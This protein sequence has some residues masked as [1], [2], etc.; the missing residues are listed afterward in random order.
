[1]ANCL[2][3]PRYAR[4]R[5][6]LAVSDTL[7]SAYSLTNPR[8]RYAAEFPLYQVNRLVD[9]WT[10]SRECYLYLVE[11][12]AREGGMPLR[13]AFVGNWTTGQRD[14]LPYFQHLL[15]EDDSVKTTELGE[16]QVSEV[17]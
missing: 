13:T 4:S 12:Q 7:T 2:W 14:A 17:R 6:K 11:G 9:R 10:D 5:L 3:V 8:L 15:Y 16:C 1:M